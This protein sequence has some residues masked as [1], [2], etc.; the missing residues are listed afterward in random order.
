M[1]ICSINSFFQIIIITDGIDSL[2]NDSSSKVFCENIKVKLLNL[3][4]KFKLEDDEFDETIN[5]ID[6][7]QN[8]TL[9]NFANDDKVNL[10]FPF[11]FSNKLNVI[12]LQEIETDYSKNDYIY[13][14]E[15]IKLNSNNGNFFLSK[16]LNINY[17]VNEFIPNVSNKIYEKFDCSLK[18]GHLECNTAVYP[19]PSKFK[20]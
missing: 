15:L 8:E 17:I 19:P 18:F 2:A 13:F 4:E 3:K 11:T 12:V 7:Y 9:Y 20:G 6:F 5:N 16:N 1:F 10:K 14:N